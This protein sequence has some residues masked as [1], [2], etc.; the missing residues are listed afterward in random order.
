MHLFRER[1]SSL[2]H[3]VIFREATDMRMPYNYFW[4]E[5]SH[6]NDFRCV[7]GKR[8]GKAAQHHS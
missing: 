1:K 6:Q 2:G 5:K 3:M 8:Q 4:T 7:L